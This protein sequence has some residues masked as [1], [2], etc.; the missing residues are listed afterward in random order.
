[1]LLAVFNLP[2]TEGIGQIAADAVATAARDLVLTPKRRER[3]YTAVAEA[4]MNA[5]EHGNKLRPDRM[6]DFIVAATHEKV[7]ITVADHGAA[8]P[9][10]WPPKPDLDAK[11]AG[12]ESA[13]GWGLF[14]IDSL[15]DNCE[16][17]ETPT[18]N[19]VE[20]TML[21]GADLPD[22]VIGTK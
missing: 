18:G 19:S 1:M 11:L 10:A 3:L 6:V 21:L 16:V 15:V 17:R 20:L 14:L 13:R 22:K 12:L 7:T 5:A 8:G 9:I 2:S 4:A